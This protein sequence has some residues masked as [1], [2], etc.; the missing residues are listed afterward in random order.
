MDLEGGG[1]PLDVPT[2]ALQRRFHVAQLKGPD[3]FLQRQGA[4][5]HSPEQHVHRVRHFGERGALLGLHRRYRTS[6]RSPTYTGP[7]VT[8]SFTVAQWAPVVRAAP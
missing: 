1:G 4:V 7:S 8:N 6:T 5:Q 2:V 3:R